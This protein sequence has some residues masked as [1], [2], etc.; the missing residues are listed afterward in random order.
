MKKT[1]D[2]LI[3]E[4]LEMDETAKFIKP[5]KPGSGGGS[6]GDDDQGGSGAFES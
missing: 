6:G 3:L 1:W 4:I 5:P 2:N